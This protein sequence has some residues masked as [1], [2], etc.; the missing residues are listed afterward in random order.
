MIIFIAILILACVIAVAS[1]SNE[2]AQKAEE[3]HHLDMMRDNGVSADEI[4]AQAERYKQ[5]WD[6]WH[7]YLNRK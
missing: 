7:E 2:A 5:S 4:K 6:D 1:T 3:K